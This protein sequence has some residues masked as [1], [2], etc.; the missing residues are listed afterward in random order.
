MATLTAFAQFSDATR[1]LGRTLSPSILPIQGRPRHPATALVIG[2][3]RLLTT[4]HSVE[5]D[6]HVR[7]RVPEGP[8]LAATVVGRDSA[9]DLVVLHAPGLGVAPIAWAEDAPET[10]TLGLVLG[11]G[12]GGHLVC[13]LVALTRL[14]GP[15]RLGRGRVV[16]Q[17]LGLGLSPYTGFSGSA[18]VTADGRVAGISTTGLSRGAGLAVPAT[19]ARATADALARD[20]RIRRGFLGVSTQPVVLPPSQRPNGSPEAGLLVVAVGAGS[21]SSEAG[22]L[23][24]DIVVSF[25]AV[26]VADPED[27]LSRLTAERIGRAVPVGVVRGRDAQMLTVTVGER[28]DA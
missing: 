4:S 21:P 3:E 22:L 24:G 17:L 2:P 28:P 25:D 16:G 13:R 6:D 5:W 20:G 26:A 10:G 1:E 14:E 9:T 11:R 19:V 23:V 8:A 18:V 27:L 15:I 7:V 12:W